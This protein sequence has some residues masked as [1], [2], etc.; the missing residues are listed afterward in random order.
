MDNVHEL[1]LWV[2]KNIK[3]SCHLMYKHNSNVIGIDKQYI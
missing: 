3:I 1:T 2:K